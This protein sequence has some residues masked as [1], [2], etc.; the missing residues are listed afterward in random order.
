MAEVLV[1]DTSLQAIADAIREKNGTETTYKPSEMGTAIRAIESEGGGSE[2]CGIDAV[3]FI[4]VD[5]TIA[6]STET[7]VKYTVDEL[8]FVTS[9]VTD[10]Y[11]TF[12]A[13]DLYIA[14]ITPKEITGEAT[15]EEIN[16]YN[17]SLV[18]M[19]GNTNYTPIIASIIGVGDNKIQV[20]NYGIYG[21][22][23]YC[24]AITNGK[25]T[26][27]MTLSV[28]HS[29]SSGYE[30]LEGTYNVQVYHL[31]NFNLGV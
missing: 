18:L 30:V 15:G 28:R 13:K 20:A 21:V 23:L 25:V 31:T 27:Y 24:T 26:G 16:I 4:D 29:T 10:K 14:F 12:T 2:S 9:V 1:Q 6:P 3:K 19:Y 11:S 17:K 8:E 5:I 22:T 7:A